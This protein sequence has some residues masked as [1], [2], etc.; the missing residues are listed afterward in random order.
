MGKRD[1]L[2]KFIADMKREGVDVGNYATHP[3]GV[4]FESL[5]AAKICAE[6]HGGALSRIDGQVSGWL[7]K[8]QPSAPAIVSLIAREDFK[9][10]EKGYATGESVAHKAPDGFVPEGRFVRA[11]EDV[12][13]GDT[14]RFEEFERE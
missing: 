11:L 7:V 1:E 6:R 4:V 12:Q 9:S 3:E 14:G 10:G 5:K 13:R 2:A 8:N